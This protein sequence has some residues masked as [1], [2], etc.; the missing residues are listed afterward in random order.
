MIIYH[1]SF[2]TFYLICTISLQAPTNVPE[3]EKEFVRL[4]EELKKNGDS[5]SDDEMSERFRINHQCRLPEMP[6]VLA[7]SYANAGT[8]WRGT[9]AIADYV[10]QSPSISAAKMPSTLIMRGEF[11][12]VSES[13][14]EA[15]KD[16]FNT[17][18]LRYKTLEGCS[19]H[20]MLENG[21]LYGELVDSY[22]GEY[23]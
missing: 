13:S 9:N 17:K 15:W 22:F 14:V 8:V 23:D 20:A 5:V 12:F 1:T 2:W 4:L 7:E 19:H 10:A 6:E 16:V 11:D 3:I 21:E 18:F